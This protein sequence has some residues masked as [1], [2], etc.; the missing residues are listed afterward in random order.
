M[1][2]LHSDMYTKK[3]TKNLPKEAVFLYFV[4][5]ILCDLSLGLLQVFERPQDAFHRRNMESFSFS[6]RNI[7]WLK[8]SSL[9]L[10][11][12]LL[13][14]TQRAKDILKSLSLA[15]ILPC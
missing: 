3:I 7:K 15:E 14:Q 4:P 12:Y 10:K 13:F 8:S 6:G 1:A 9:F 2:K 11:W 5:F